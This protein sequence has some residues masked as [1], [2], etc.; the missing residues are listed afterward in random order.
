MKSVADALRAESRARGA[1]LEVTARVRR[2]LELGD[3]DAR[4]FA[5][6]RE[7]SIQDARRSMQRQRQ[8]GR[9]RSACH[10]SLLQ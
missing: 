8:Q 9:R 4:M 1:A 6:A 7:I 5:A 10:E 3:A 2:A